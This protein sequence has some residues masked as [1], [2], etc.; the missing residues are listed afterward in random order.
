MIGIAA[1][2]LNT[3]NLMTR[4]NDYVKLFYS[5]IIFLIYSANNN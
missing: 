3:L 1:D 4:I 5:V 2:F